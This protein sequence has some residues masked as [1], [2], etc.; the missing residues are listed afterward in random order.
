MVSASYSRR[1]AG[2]HP[3]YVPAALCAGEIVHL[4]RHYGTGEAIIT[5]ANLNNPAIT[6]YLYSK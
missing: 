4:K 2:T 5:K 3:L 6:E 1:A